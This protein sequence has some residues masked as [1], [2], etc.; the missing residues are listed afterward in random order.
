MLEG[1]VGELAKHNGLKHK[2]EMSRHRKGHTN[3]EH[4]VN[5]WEAV[6]VVKTCYW[7]QK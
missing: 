6:P 1:S 5:K 4:A 2:G 3:N 7:W